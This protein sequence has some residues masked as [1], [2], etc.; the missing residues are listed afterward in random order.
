MDIALTSR[1]QTRRA[2]T[3]L[4]PTPGKLFGMSDSSTIR[5][6]AKNS[7]HP[8]R[9]LTRRWLAGIAAI[10]GLIGIYA[11]LAPIDLTG[12]PARLALFS[13]F[14]LTSYWAI[15]AVALARLTR[16]KYPGT[17]GIILLLLLFTILLLGFA[18]LYNSISVFEPGT[19]TTN[20][21]TK[22]SA[23]YFSVTTLSTV[24]FGEISPAND[25]ART[26]VMAQ[27]LLDLA[28][29]GLGVKLLSQASKGRMQTLAN[30]SEDAA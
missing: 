13:T 30:E 18:Y 19:F 20:M 23:I 27:M 5:E 26:I 16:S 15:F 2:A 11:L 10:A 1:L 21:D 7:N 14:M 9:D 17:D 4:R 25:T 22:L 29:L 28:L 24:G 3:L 12:H 8:R 6:M